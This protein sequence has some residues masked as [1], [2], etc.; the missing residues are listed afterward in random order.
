MRSAKFRTPHQVARLGF[1]A[2]V[3][4]LGPS[5]AVRFILQYESGKGDYTKERKK[6]FGHKSVAAIIEEMRAAPAHKKT[7]S[8]SHRRS[9]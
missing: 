7:R 4:K 3:E 9:S 2:L 1:D 8:R 5:D 6:L